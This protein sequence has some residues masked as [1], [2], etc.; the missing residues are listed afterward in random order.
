M[1]SEINWEEVVELNE[2]LITKATY[3]ILWIGENGYSI[4]RFAKLI[5]VRP[6]YYKNQEKMEL[7]VPTVD[8]ET[9]RYTFVP[10]RW[11]I[12]AGGVYPKLVF[13]KDI[14]KVY[15]KEEI[16]K[17]ILSDLDLGVNTKYLLANGIKKK[18]YGIIY[19]QDIPDMFEPLEL[20]E[21]EIIAKLYPET[22][23]IFKFKQDN[24][25]FI[26]YIMPKD[27]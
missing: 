5:K 27:C 2:V 18:T 6:S 20:N 21:G 11:Y 22:F 17:I 7:V 12:V 14:I 4:T 3:P 15:R 13:V 25:I 26:K 24:R 19:E 9:K 23:K 1:E 10:D 8:F 16:E